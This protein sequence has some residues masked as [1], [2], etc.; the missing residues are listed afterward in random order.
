MSRSPETVKS[1]LKTIFRKLGVYS[2]HEIKHLFAAKSG[3]YAVNRQFQVGGL[4]GARGKPTVTVSLTWQV[5]PGQVG[6]LL[7]SIMGEDTEGLTSTK[8]GGPA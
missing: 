6:E 5:D 7:E 4:P 1:H 8:L 2:R 3:K